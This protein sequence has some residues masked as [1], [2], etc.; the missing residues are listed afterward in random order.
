ME[1]LAVKKAVTESYAPSKE[2]KLAPE[3]HMFSPLARGADRLAAQAALDL[4][5]DLS[6]PMPFAQA[7]YEK[8]FTGSDKDHPEEVPLAAHQDLEE[9]RHLLAQSSAQM[10]IDS[11][12]NAEPSGEDVSAYAYEAVGRFV[13]RHCDLLIAVWDGSHGNGRGGTADI[14]HY[15]AVSG[16]PIWWIHAEREADPIWLS[17]IQD[18][19]DPLPVSESPEQKLHTH[20]A[21]LIPAPPRVRRHHNNWIGRLASVHREKNVSPASVYFSE[22][23]K[24]SNPIWKTYSKLMAW[25]SGCKPRYPQVHEPVEPIAR[26]WFRHYQTADSRASQYAARYRSSYVW[27]ISL[28]T[29]SVIIGAL[30][31]SLL[32][33]KEEWSRVLAVCELATLIFIVLV[34]WASLRYE[35]HE[36]SIEYRL[37]A[38]LFRKQETLASLGWSLS[39]GH[40][41]HLADTQ[42]LSWVSWLFAAMQRSAPLPQASKMDNETARAMLQHLIDEQITYHRDR[43]KMSL[44]AAERF[45]GLGGLAFGIVLLC[46]ILKVGS[47]AINGL[48]YMVLA[49][50]VMAIILPGIS[51]ACLAIRSYAELQLLAEQ[52]R[53]MISELEHSRIRVARLNISRP[54]VSQDL[55]AEAA[56]VGTTMLQDLEGWGR[57]FRGKLMEA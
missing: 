13:V 11:R 49:L 54:L 2:G 45:E 56:I 14:V 21:R 10:T 47:E 17:D 8:D 9:F 38:E 6:V 1:H 42:R 25:A 16:V 23:P 43:E 33:V 22:E 50:A 26:Y 29:L 3:L 4:H 5:Y 46:V 34:V 37:L 36:R 52:S 55:G 28:T 41:Q 27:V 57:L 18:L 15:A 20:L 12:R 30:A 39:I 35:W 19:R 51:A 40:V 44:N 24:P 7:E 32:R 31:L 53:Y 48:P